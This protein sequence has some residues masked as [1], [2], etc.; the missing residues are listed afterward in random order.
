M[1]VALRDRNPDETR[2]RIPSDR[3]QISSGTMHAGYPTSKVM[4]DNLDDFWRAYGQ[5]RSQ[6]WIQAEYFYS[7]PGPESPPPAGF[8]PNENIHID[9]V[10]LQGINR[11]MPRP[12]DLAGEFYRENKA[13]LIIDTFPEA[14]HNPRVASVALTNLTGSYSVLNQTIN[15]PEEEIVGGYSPLA[16]ESTSATLDTEFIAEFGNNSGRPIRVGANLQEIQVHARHSLN[17]DTFPVIV[18]T[19]RQGGVDL[20]TLT[21]NYVEKTDEGYI[22]SYLWDATVLSDLT[23]PVF[24]KVHGTKTTVGGNSTPEYIAVAWYAEVTGTLFDSGWQTIEN[25]SHVTWAPELELET[26]ESGAFYI[27][28]QFSDFS[29][30]NFDVVGIP[31]GGNQ[32]VR[33]YEPLDQAFHAGRFVSGPAL[34][35]PLWSTSAGALN[36]RRVGNNQ[37]IGTSTYGGQLRAIRPD[38]T[39]KQIDITTIPQP[40]ERFYSEIEPLFIQLGNVEHSLFVDN[41]RIIQGEDPPSHLLQPE[42][43]W[44]I[45]TNFECPDI[46]VLQGGDGEGTEAPYTQDK[47]HQIRFSILQTKADLTRRE[48]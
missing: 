38:M 10:S 43:I 9:I 47:Y 39:R 6:T 28:I 16:L 12:S 42:A 17:N 45:V 19:I 44:G 36:I 7:N 35:L 33:L 37:N 3:W 21:L 32:D 22:F 29:K 4:T 13:R 41:L 40:A 26:P 5:R 34:N 48:D 11:K 46:G 15:P 8:I 18:S 23:A 20:H 25:Y 2:S 30:V 31:G 14:W 1:L 24:L 27:F